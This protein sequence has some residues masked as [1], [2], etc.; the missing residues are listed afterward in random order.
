ML[1]YEIDIL[2]APTHKYH[3]VSLTED[4]RVICMYSR[5]WP[6]RYHIH[7]NWLVRARETGRVSFDTNSNT[8]TTIGLVVVIPINS[9]VS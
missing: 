4:P 2:W 8:P 6:I 7:L 1:A 3:I 5:P 9:L